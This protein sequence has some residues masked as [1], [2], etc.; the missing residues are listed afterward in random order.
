[1]V[2][3]TKV[4]FRE[5]A[6]LLYSLVYQ[7]PMMRL[8][9]SVAAVLLLWILLFHL[10]LFNLPTPTIYQYI[11]LG[12]IALVQPIVVFFTIWRNYHSSN[13]LRE[14]LKMEMTKSELKITGESF[15]LEVKWEKLFKIVRKRHYFLAYQNNLSAIIIPIKDMSAVEIAEFKEILDNLTR[16]PQH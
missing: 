8:L 7:K 5:Y 10:N 3:Q 6:K 13:H 9:V 16:V 15:Y 2:I 12:L 1:M 11:T 4:T 14:T